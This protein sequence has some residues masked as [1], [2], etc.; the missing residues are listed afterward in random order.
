MA[1]AVGAGDIAV[2]AG[3]GGAV[4]T[5]TGVSVAGVSVTVA[6]GVSVVAVAGVS[7]VAVAGVS[8]RA[9]LRPEVAEGAGVAAVGD[10]RTWPLSY[11]TV[12]VTRP[13]MPSALRPC[14]YWNCST[15]R[16]VWLPYT[17]S[18]SPS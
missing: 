17:P 2:T 8:V 5:A 6:A 1:V 9:T 3:L 16:R 18:I 13:A 4:M 12:S 11:S 15:A 14:W 10:M 7:V